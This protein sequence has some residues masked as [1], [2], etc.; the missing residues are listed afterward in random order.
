MRHPILYVFVAKESMANCVGSLFRYKISKCNKLV[1]QP[2][3]IWGRRKVSELFLSMRRTP[4]YI[5]TAKG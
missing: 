3:K 5:P 4:Y 1:I 2:L